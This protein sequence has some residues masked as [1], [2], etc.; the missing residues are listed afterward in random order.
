MEESY[1]DLLSRTR[2]PQAALQKQ[3][4]V[5]LFDKLVTSPPHL[6]L[7]SSIGRDAITQCLHSPS[8]SVLNQ[9][10]LQLIKLVINNDSNYDLSRALI[11][12]QAAL[13][14]VVLNNPGLVSVFVKGLG[15]L[16]RFGFQN[17]D[18]DFLL[19]SQSSLNH[20]FVKILSCGIEVHS[21]LVQQVLAFVTQSSH[22][23]IEEICEFLRPFLN[24]AI[25]Q[26]TVSVSFLSFLQKLIPAMSSLCCS[27]PGKSIPIIKF[28]M[29]SLKFFPCKNSE[30]V[31][32]VL[33][34]VEYLVD[35]YLVVLT[36]LVNT[37]STVH[38]AQLYLVELLEDI[39][40]LH[41]DLYR[42][43]NL[44]DNILRIAKHSLVVQK[45]LGLSFIPEYSTI[46]MSLFMMLIKS[47]LEHEQYSIAKFIT[48]LLKWK[49]EHENSFV[50]AAST[51]NEE[52]LFILPIFNV[53]SSPSMPVKRA[54]TELLFILGKLS[55]ELLNSPLKLPD[56]EKEFSSSS[57]PESIILRCVK[58]LSFQDQALESCHSYLHLVRIGDSPCQNNICRPWMSLLA[59][60]SMWFMGKLK[61][62]VSITESQ[63]IFLTEMP[64][65]LGAISSVM[66]MNP[67]FSSYA[68]DLLVACGALDPSLS[69]SLLLTVPFFNHIFSAEHEDI[70]V[71]SVVLKLLHMI[72]SLASHS[73][74]VPLVVQTILPMLQKDTNPALIATATRLICKAWEVNDRVFGS[75]QVCFGGMNSLS[76]EMK[77]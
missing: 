20:P 64:L 60:Y 22:A 39:F 23:R 17:K 62:P 12:L 28:L 57:T 3:A 21:E 36:E 5:T 63:E 31:A 46:K 50:G 54:A 13:E 34:W 52:L 37:R 43:G 53:Q 42:Y 48:F 1:S 30:D 44:V 74:M 33:H 58:H 65:I 75:L 2:V 18:H 67:T 59:E 69:V 11:D 61:S 26:V 29:S 9:S 41:R 73:A 72:P 15:V 27:L 6:G 19:I 7:N 24:Y 77:K 38:E 70:N 55:T 14:Q 66:I 51:L 32:Y 47:Q 76:K 49:N 56:T 8:P 10:I 35:A 45:N 68:I 71:H 25:V 40:S 16:I 4:V